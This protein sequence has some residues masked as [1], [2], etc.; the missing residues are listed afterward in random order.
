MK[1]SYKNGHCVFV[2]I[3][4]IMVQTEHSLHGYKGQCLSLNLEPLLVVYE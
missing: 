4:V 3:S 1:K 2:H